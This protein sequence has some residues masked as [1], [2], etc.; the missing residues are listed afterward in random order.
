MI[1]EI[2][3]RIGQRISDSIKEKWVN[4]VL[5]IEYIG[6]VKCFLQYKKPDGTAGNIAL[7][8]SFKNMR[9]IKDLH[10]I[11][12]EDGKNKWNKAVFYLNAD[13]SFNMEFEWDQ[14]LQDEIE[15]LCQK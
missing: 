4:A 9:D 8:D 10:K 15:K 12:T 11:M 1:N 14:K 5:Q 2:Y 3:K 7:V 6:A 13:G